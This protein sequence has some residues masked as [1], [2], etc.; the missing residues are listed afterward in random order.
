MKNSFKMPGSC[1]GVVKK[2]GVSKKKTNK[3][4]LGNTFVESFFLIKQN[5]V[6]YEQNVKTCSYHR[7]DHGCRAFQYEVIQPIISLGKGHVIVNYVID[8]IT[9][10]LASKSLNKFID[11]V[12][13]DQ[14]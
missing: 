7:S 8:C 11:N 3:L 5:I 4:V 14:G 1:V 9:Y 2:C 6:N 12:M 10:D 13:R